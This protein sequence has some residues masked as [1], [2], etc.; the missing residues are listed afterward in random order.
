MDRF[1]LQ[2]GLKIKEGDR[3]WSL[4]RRLDNGNLYL[5]SGDA[6]IRSCTLHDFHTKYLSRRWSVV[7]Q[8]LH[9]ADKPLKETAS[10]DLSTFGEK[11]RERALRKMRYVENA[12][13]SDSFVSSP[14]HLKPIIAKTAKQLGDSTPP[15]TIS[16]YRWCR[17]YLNGRKSIVSLIDHWENQGR[18]VTWGTEE[19]EG[20]ILDVI[21][22]IYLNPQKHPAKSVYKTVRLAIER[23]NRGR[24]DSTKAKC[25]SRAKIY[26]HLKNLSSYETEVARL[27]KDVADRNFRKTLSVQKTERILERWEV[28]HT[29]LNLIVVER[30]GNET[31]TI[32]KPW[33]TVILDKHSRMVMGYYLSFAH[34]ST[35]AV[36]N[37]LRMAILPKE[38]LL[39]QYPNIKHDWPVH[40]IP[41]MLVCDNGMEFHSEALKQVCLEMLVELLFCPSKRPEYKG[42][43]ERFLR[44]IVDLL[45]HLLPGTVFSNPKQRGAY[46]SEKLAC[47]DFHE[48]LEIITKWIVDVYSQTVHRELGKTPY[49]VWQESLRDRTPIE[50][51]ADPQ[52]LEIILGIPAKRKLYHYGLE[53]NRVRYNS[54]ALNRL[55]RNRKNI[56][57]QLKYYEHDLGYIHAF[58]PE[59]KEYLRIPA[60]DRDM[61]GRTIAQHKALIKRQ[62]ERKQAG[63]ISLWESEEELQNL[64]N[65][66]R[67][68][69]KMGTRKKAQVLRGVSS[70]NP[71]GIQK[72]TKPENL[73]M[74]LLP[75]ELGYGDAKLPQ[76]KVTKNLA[77]R[78]SPV[79]EECGDE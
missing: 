76:L 6:E 70:A 26:R 77:R 69:K 24:T 23:L 78:R 54:E 65:S 18:R 7:S 13:R 46:A 11:V 44:T 10:R 34:P 51:P 19:V 53:V 20:I 40:G 4:Q 12:V 1:S 33:L 62:E 75:P 21:D 5:E 63:Q 52:Q 39:S 60:I 9:N 41:E 30:I 25:P 27:G 64:A 47:I 67:A 45:V 14:K 2:R 48:L 72:R 56:E 74:P 59:S 66:A 8:E 43:V 29:P 36:M 15:S 71:N 28:D 58:D 42:A 17:S 35:E 38:G 50:L 49:A 37:C 73:S 55:F 57:V 68:S 79:I 22:K 61:D 32:G 16:V 31:V 3:E